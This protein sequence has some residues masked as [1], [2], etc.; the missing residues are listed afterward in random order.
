MQQANISLANGQGLVYRN[1]EGEV[2]RR[3]VAPTEVTAC[4][5]G[6]FLAGTPWHKYVR[7]RLERLA[8]P[9]ATNALAM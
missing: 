4:T 7:A 1:A 6:D 5:Q 9:A 8:T 3:G 2:V